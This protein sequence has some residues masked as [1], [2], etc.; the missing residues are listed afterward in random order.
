MGV[1]EVLGVT[2]GSLGRLS[3]HST[4]HQGIRG[5][6]LGITKKQGAE[7]GAGGEGHLPETNTSF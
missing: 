1:P 5:S 3:D 6:T 2:R 7:S 4:L